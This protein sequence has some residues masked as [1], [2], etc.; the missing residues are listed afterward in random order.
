LE[1]T[2]S[3]NVCEPSIQEKVFSEQIKILNQ[4]LLASVPA[5]F[6]CA[7][8][9]FVSLYNSESIS[10]ILAWII[11]VFFVSLFRLLTFYMYRR[12]PKSNDVQLIIFM[13]GLV[14]SALLWGVINSI[15]MPQDDPIHQ[16]V[17]IVIIAGVTAGGIQT[18]N[19]NLK[20]SIIYLF[21]IVGPLI[22]WLFVQGS[23]TYTLLGIAILAYLSFMIVTSIRG[24]KL[25]T[26]TL[27]LQ[28]ENHVLIENISISNAKL[29]DYSKILYEQ[30]THDALTGLFN[31]RYLDE[32]LVRELQRVIREKQSV[33]IAMLDL[34]H[35]KTFNDTH[36][37]AAGDE[38]LK[39]IAKLMKST[40]RGSD[41]CCRFGGEEF[42]VVMINTRT[43]PALFRLEQFRDLVKT[44]EVFF[45][46]K[47]LPPISV[48][49][50]VAEAPRQGSTASEIIHAA[51]TALYSAKNTGRDRVV[52]SS[53]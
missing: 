35:F 53:I 50:G 36:G 7:L 48:S 4:N 3:K 46:E 19:A 8:I 39:F 41:I 2:N 31:R 28:F 26:T 9:V 47:L 12:L 22:I 27:T 40:F 30:S 49:I 14:L 37:H 23:F 18:L 21:L 52:T 42:T 51:D 44:G 33:C 43:N 1:P 45:Q 38:V 34:D 16:M 20:A 24:Y 15:Y 25:L 11:A 10:F 6:V 5:N 17:I 32:A 13:V 29:L